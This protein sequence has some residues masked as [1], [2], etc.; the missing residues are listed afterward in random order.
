MPDGINSEYINEF[1]FIKTPSKIFKKK[2]TKTINQKKITKKIKQKN[3]L[4]PLAAQNKR[5]RSLS[6][7]ELISL[8][9]RSG[10]TTRKRAQAIE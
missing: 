5:L 7:L 3:L 1:L 8:F 10:V 4:K 9:K 2:T 6:S